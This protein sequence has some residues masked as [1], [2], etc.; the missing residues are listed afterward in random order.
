MTFEDVKYGDYYCRYDF[1]GI[2]TKVTPS[3]ITMF[4][5]WHGDASSPASIDTGYS[6]KAYDWDHRTTMADY[7][8]SIPNLNDKT[9][10]ISKIFAYP[11]DAT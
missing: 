7:S 2:V 11:L 9:R 4:I 5:I 8:T 6:Y 10:I 3:H 1:E